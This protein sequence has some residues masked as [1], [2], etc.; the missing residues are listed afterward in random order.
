M[1]QSKHRKVLFTAAN[2]QTLH[3]VLNTASSL[4]MLT[5]QIFQLGI[6][7]NALICFL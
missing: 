2:S 6:T 3:M 4:M 7:S 1:P 5:I